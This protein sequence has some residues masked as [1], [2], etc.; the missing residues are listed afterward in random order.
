MV[1]RKS[2]GTKL[3]L[4]VF[5][6]TIVIILI[7]WFLMLLVEYRKQFNY[8]EITISNIQEWQLEGL[9]A[10]V[11]D[12]SEDRINFAIKAIKANQFVSDVELRYI[13]RTPD[14]DEE[15]TVRIERFT[16]THPIGGEIGYLYVFFSRK[17][18]REAVFRNTE[19][20]IIV[21]IPIL[22][23]SGIFLLLF[24]TLVTKPLSDLADYTSDLS[25]ENISREF[26]FYRK[27]VFDPANE[28]GILLNAINK[29][30]INIREEDRQRRSA[31]KSLEVL[32]KS[33]QDII[34]AIPSII[35]S[36]DKEKKITQWNK[37]AE[38]LTGYSSEQTVGKPVQT[39]LPR[40]SSTMDKIQSV[41]DKNIIEAS[42]SHIKRE[43]GT[44]IFEEITISPL[45][46]KK[47]EGA[48]IRIDDVSEKRKLEELLV[49][50]E[51][52]LS[53]GGLAAGI[54]HEINNPLAGI[55]QN[56]SVLSNRLGINKEIQANR[57]AAEELGISIDVIYQYLKRR[58]IPRIM[59]SMTEGGQRVAEI[60]KNM[61][62]FA[63][64]SENKRSSFKIE[65]LI[66]DTLKL[67]STEYNL[68]KNYDFRKIE[69]NRDFGT[70]IPQVI[71]E[72]AKI[73]QVILNLLQNGAQAMF[74]IKR[75]N[76]I[77]SFTIR[78]ALE[79]DEMVRI[80]IQDNGPGMEKSIQSRIF[81]PFFTTKEE[82]SGTGL[83]LSVS[84]F[85]ITE[86]HKGKLSVHSIPGK[87]TTFTILLPLN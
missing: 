68:N 38:I 83:G 33:L 84:Y 56:A 36:I 21:L 54:A 52:M 41:I 65:S 50:N 80:D 8:I 12:L 46:T 28:L 66:D 20:F 44:E 82:G 48:V 71:C 37:E 51:K 5:S 7:I 53:I 3:A 34:N 15:D 19:Y 16:L 79:K 6:F 14:Y 85:I 64:K 31:E 4:I 24:R 55:M 76:Y 30:R 26:K 67:I 10:A 27:K 77:P 23:M 87:G 75:K 86:N 29:M 47:N 78:T 72:R 39:M 49:Q 1:N 58:D 9:S 73:Q 25:I 63:R 43:D 60:V 13:E 11:W 18:L 62:S 57:K 61:L 59:S 74:S 2:V 22:F 70:N 35:I 42:T 40:L 45:K 81:E 69:I 32:Q 17:A